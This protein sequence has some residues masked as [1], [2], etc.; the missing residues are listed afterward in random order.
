M[1]AKELTQV[2]FKQ[3][4]LIYKDEKKEEEWLDEFFNDDCKNGSYKKDIRSCSLVQQK[5]KSFQFVHKSI[6]KFLIAAD[7]FEILLQSKQ[8]DARIYSTILEIQFSQNKNESLGCYIK[9]ITEKHFL[10]IFS[11]KNLLSYQKQQEKNAIEEKVKK[12]I[13]F[14]YKLRN[15]DFNIINYSTKTYEESRKFLIQKIQK[16]QNIIQFLKFIVH[17]TSIDE[18]LI[19]GGSNSLNI[20]VEKK[21]DLTQQSFRNVRIK[22]T[23]LIGASFSQCDLSGSEFENVIIHGI[24]LNCAI[25]ILY[26]KIFKQMSYIKQKDIMELQIQYPILMMSGEVLNKLYGHNVSVKSVSFSDGLTLASGSEDNSIRIQ[27]INSGQE[28]L[29]LLGHDRGV[30]TLFFSSNASLLASGSWDKSIHF[31]NVNSAELIKILQGHSEGVQSV[32]FSPDDTILASCSR[33]KSIFIWSVRSGDKKKIHVERNG[34]LISLSFSPDGSILVCDKSIQFFDIK[35]GT[36]TKILQGHEG[37][38]TSVS[39]SPDGL[40]LASGSSDKSIRLWDIESGKEKKII[41]GHDGNGIKLASGGEDKSIYLWDVKSGE[42]TKIL[43]GHNGQVSSL[44]FSTDG[45]VLASGSWDNTI[46]LWDVKLGE[47]KCILQGHNDYVLS[48]CFSPDSSILVSRSIDKSICIWNINCQQEKEIFP[49]SLVSDGLLPKSIKYNLI[50][51]IFKKF[52][53]VIK[54]TPKPIIIYN[55][56]DSVI[57]QINQKIQYS[58]QI[59]KIIFQVQDIVTLIRI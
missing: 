25:L 18:G 2:Q 49:Q 58:I 51:Y 52:N 59:Q 15:H 28:I 53:T 56:L 13:E 19:Q 6:Q 17:L 38:V 57:L 4:G 8:F 50:Q 22:N 9:Q 5:G 16:D 7:L 30:I 45:T 23:S 42:K 20:L 10:K 33:D 37:I 54:F 12:T 11:M 47:G 34:G 55:R 24:N 31:W 1:S 32:C 36:F 46:R 3:Q 39:F 14:V 44:C 29:T 35:L 26:G 41:N 40:Q 43:K 27:D 48:I 21:V